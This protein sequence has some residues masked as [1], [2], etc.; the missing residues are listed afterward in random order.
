VKFI[1]II[2]ELLFFVFC[3]SALGEPWRML[4]RKFTGLFKGVDF[5]RAFLLNVYLGGFL[6]YVI[7]IVPL[8]LFSAVVLHVITLVSI[9]TVVLL[10]R[11]RLK[12]ALSP[13]LSHPATLL[14][15]RPSLELALVLAIFAFSLVIQTYPLNDL[16]L[17]SVRDTGIHSLF[18]QVL[19]ENRQVP[20]TLEPY[21]S[22]GII[23]PQG[24]T[25][26]VAYSVLILGY[27]PPQA[28]LYVT[29]L[30]NILTVLGAYFLGKTLPLPEKLKTGLCLAFVFAFVA[31]WPKYIT[32]GSNALVASVPFYFICLSLFPFLLKEKLNVRTTLAVGLLY[33]YL[34]VLHLQVY[35]MLIASLFVLLV[36]MIIKREKGRGLRFGYFMAI[37]SVSLIV[38][39][40]F[41]MRQ[42]AFYSNPYHNIG[43]PS[44]VEIPIP[45]PS[46]STVISAAKWLFENLA[47]DPVLKGAS[48]A[49]ILVSIM[50][51]VAL[52]R[53]SGS[54]QTSE[55]LKLGLATLLGEL[56]IALFAAISPRDLPFYPQPLLLYLPAYFFFAAIIY[57]S[58][59]LLSSYLSRKVEPKTTWSE[60]KMKRV[61]VGAIS[62]M[63]LIG[64]FG[65][66][67]YQSVAFDATRLYGSYS[68]FGTTTEQD[69]QLILWIRDNLPAN[70]TILVNTFQ[71][72]TFIP[73]IA[74]R[75]AVF[76]SF[77]S[78]TSVFYQKLVSLLEEGVLNNTTLDLM[79]RF[80]ITDIY[81]GS[82]I[83]P[84]D[85]GIH[86]WNP[87]LFLGNPHFGLAK[88][89]GDAYLFHL[90]YTDTDSVFYDDFEHTDWEE[91]G[92]QTGYYGNGLGNVAIATDFGYLSQRSL[93]ITTQAMYSLSEWKYARYVSR[94]VFVSNDS[95]V[96]LS[97]YLKATEGFHGEDAFAVVVSNIYRNQS[98]IVTTPHGVYEDYANTKTLEGFEGLFSCDLTVS[99]R[100]FFDSSLPSTFILEFV[101][102]DFDG[103]RNV[104]Y[105]DNV[106]IASLPT[107]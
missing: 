84:W 10:H 69:L 29:A 28:V 56:L 97:F 25:P 22:E 83:S 45:Q 19:I 78:S 13:A 105:V 16:L 18:V 2:L 43:V 85:G 98:M 5:L 24:F 51:I 74:S 96:V 57:P 67:V 48:F 65:T 14:K 23:Y 6:L 90:N 70:A 63:L 101:N 91:D 79:K 106:N 53:R 47:A 102:W 9:V 89:F 73:S 66:F 99:W 37:T 40:P 59:D 103:I 86:R 42:L 30:F 72:G 11:R 20:V 87:R 92:W 1:E 21:L 107:T 4:I 54:I 32:W 39:S 95:D 75:K 31:S 88:K 93:R 58:Y 80:N 60:L 49:L 36:Y 52:R 100:Q 27:S 94:E 77:G 35:E 76:P 3:L 61:L 64:L 55:L 38:L 12:D 81:A 34:S 71:S 41:I 82:G 33:G 44:D 68:V 7:A 50:V 104:A 17:G 15:K 26:M 8:H 46:L 62:V